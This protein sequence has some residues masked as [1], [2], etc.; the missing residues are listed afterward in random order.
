MFEVNSKLDIDRQTG[1]TLQ[2]LR[3]KQNLEAG[4]IGTESGSVVVW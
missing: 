1:R 3:E 4:L 2:I